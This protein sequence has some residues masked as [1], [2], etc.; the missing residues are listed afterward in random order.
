MPP[1]PADQQQSARI[2][3]RHELLLRPHVRNL[4]LGHPLLVTHLDLCLRASR[5]LDEGSA[6]DAA[7]TLGID[8]EY[9]WVADRIARELRFLTFTQLLAYLQYVQQAAS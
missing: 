8:V 4:R 1:P 9:V 7:E 5:L 3:A 2:F 6:H